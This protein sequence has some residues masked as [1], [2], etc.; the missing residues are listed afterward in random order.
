ME[1]K[2]IETNAYFISMEDRITKVVDTVAES[3]AVE[4]IVFS[5]DELKKLVE[6]FRKEIKIRVE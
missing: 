1:K 4:G 2:I 3:F 5:E 6:D